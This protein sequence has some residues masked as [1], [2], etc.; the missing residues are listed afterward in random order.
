M[1][2]TAPDR[3]T[4]PGPG[5]R[6]AVGAI[7]AAG[8]ALAAG[9]WW[10]R[11]DDEALPE[12]VERALALREL[13]PNRWVRYHEERPGDWTRQAH[14]GMALDA[15]RGTLLVFGS[16]TH[17]QDWDNAVH[18]FD[19]L[20]ERWHTHQRAAGVQTYRI[21]ADGAPVAGSDAL[22]PWA[23]HTY[24]A[25]EYHPGLDA[26]VVMSTTEHNPGPG[27]LPGMRRQPTW[28]YDLSTRRWSQ[29]DPVAGQAPS[30]FGGA[31]AFDERRGVLVAYR[32]GIWELDPA[33]R[34]WRRASSESP[35]SMHQT[36]AYDSRRGAM[37][38]FGDYRPTNEVWRYDPGAVAGAHG[39]WTRHVPGGDPC[40]PHS[41]VPV[42]YDAAQDLFV[43]VVDERPAGSPRAKP[44]SASTYFYDPAR[45]L[46]LRLA[47][48][49]LPPLGMNF[50][51]A[52]DRRHG[53]AW[54]VTGDWGSPVT[55]WAMKPSR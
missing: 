39:R 26:L 33:T 28:L 17:G 48:A 55:V 23:M 47:D 40:P 45:D 37:F 16:D 42:A 50:M 9:G 34:A 10:L 41:S 30:F 36:M 35:H 7:A 46:Y 15:R 11:R 24:D 20:L 53:V 22:M 44:Q 49:D 8:A 38:V 3:K 52:W 13:A 5:R 54:L 27:P 51:M 14:A 32:R 1:T 18:E 6:H 19:P 31:S 12:P 43:L 29:L 2:R 4:R 25:I 21:D